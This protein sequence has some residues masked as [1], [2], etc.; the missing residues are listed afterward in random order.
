MSKRSPQTAYAAFPYRLKQKWNEIMR[1]VPGISTFLG[2]LE[3]VIRNVFISVITNSRSHSNLDGESCDALV[4]TGCTKSIS[5]KPIRA[6][7]TREDV[8]VTAISGEWYSYP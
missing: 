4:E 7:W 2:P 3:D 6:Q 1:A 8:S 5:Y